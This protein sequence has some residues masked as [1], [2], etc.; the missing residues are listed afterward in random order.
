M[1]SVY[2]FQPTDPVY[3]V[4][5]FIDQNTGFELLDILKYEDIITSK[6]EYNSRDSS[7]LDL[8]LKDFTLVDE[9]FEVDNKQIMLERLYYDDNTIDDDYTKNGKYNQYFFVNSCSVTLEQTTEGEKRTISLQAFD[10]SGF[11]LKRLLHD[12]TSGYT[13]PPPTDPN[14]GAYPD[15]FDKIKYPKSTF[16]EPSNPDLNFIVD[17]V[18]RHYV[19]ES[20]FPS[21]KGVSPL[22]LVYIRN[23][24]L[25]DNYIFNNENFVYDY[26]TTQDKKSV[27]DFLTQMFNTA[28]SNNVTDIYRPFLKFTQNSNFLTLSLNGNKSIQINNINSRDFPV[29][30]T[31]KIENIGISPVSRFVQQTGDN[32]NSVSGGG[33]SINQW[34]L[35]KYWNLEVGEDSDNTDNLVTALQAL[36]EEQIQENKVTTDLEIE[37]KDLKYVKDFF[38]NDTLELINFNKYV[39][40]L[41]QIRKI[42]EIIENDYVSYSIDELVDISTTLNESVDKKEEVYE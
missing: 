15:D 18:Y 7:V 13:A 20:S 40:G 39:D 10:F 31:K 28:V 23:C 32:Y 9:I 42:T 25:I 6:I 3:Y 27:F 37:F 35:P 19:F 14:T 34:I 30:I 24:K 12:Q 26:Y 41:Y 29:S 38:I 33:G 5:R 17:F 22:E 8:T 4:H 2:S 36:D 1:K 16:G 21:E 11:F